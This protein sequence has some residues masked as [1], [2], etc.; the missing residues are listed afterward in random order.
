MR[1]IL[2]RRILGRPYYC[3][4][5]TG[6]L[7]LNFVV[8]RIFRQNA[9]VPYS[10]HYTSK[11]V[12]I[13]QMT[14]GEKAKLSLAISGGAFIKA[15]EGSSIRIGEGTIFA[16]NVTIHTG[17]HDLIDREKI[18]LKD[19]SI[20]QNCWIGSGASILSGVT[21]GDNVT[22]GSNAVVTKDFPSNVVIGGVP[23]KIIKHIEV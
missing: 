19:I 16:N 13:K 14:L 22:V 4:I 8:Q 9:E 18:I 1:R 12:G 7:L 5:P 10:V 3:S 11:L 15:F 2:Y 17:N 20:G 23:A 6:L 21:L